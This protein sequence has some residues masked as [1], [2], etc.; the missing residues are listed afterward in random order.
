M[1]NQRVTVD[2][3]NGIGPDRAVRGVMTGRLDAE[4]I[5]RVRAVPIA[6][7]IHRRGMHLQRVGLELV[8]ACPVC[9][10]G[11]KGSRSNRFAVHLRKNAWLCRRCQRGGGVVDLVMHL[12]GVGFHEAVARLAGETHAAPAPRCAPARPQNAANQSVGAPTL[13]SRH[14]PADDGQQRALK[15]W[16][17]AGP[18]AGTLAERYLIETRKLVLPPE[19]SPRALRFHPACPF[20]EGARHPCLLALYRS[21]IADE[22]RAIMRTAL[23][24]DA[25]KIDRKALGPV[26]AAAIKLSA[27]KDVTMG[28]TI[29]EGLE[30]TLA[31]LMP[32]FD[33]APA[34]AL[35]S[36][37]G[38][39]RFPVLSGIEALTVLAET[40]D[41]GAN[42]RAIRE[43]F[44]RW[45]AAGREV[46]RATSLIGGDLND[47]LTMAVV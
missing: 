22:A 6:D 41:D 29:G 30:T 21:V 31:G 36:A 40:D 1:K 28:L 16:D 18:I 27:D 25:C 44:A 15:L 11:G 5:A 34:W 10:D 45:K 7:E 23:A 19:I 38:I 13:M 8:G 12:D 3:Q 4:T 43:C 42:E 47:A 33:L 35:G 20:G 39:A 14:E 46:Y 32:G 37:G 9:G 17:E 24:P 26:G 2:F